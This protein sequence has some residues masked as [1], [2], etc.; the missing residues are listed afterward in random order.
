MG[1]SH[2]LCLALIFNLS[3]DKTD[4]QSIVAYES[5]LPLE[6]PQPNAGLQLVKSSIEKE[7]NFSNGF[8]ICERFKYDLLRQ[9]F[10]PMFFFQPGSE[11]DSY[12]NSAY[13]YLRNDHSFCFFFDFNYIVKDTDSNSFKL[14]TPGNWHHVCFSFDRTS[15]HLI[16]IKDGS[17]TSF[18]TT[19]PNDA[20][21][22]ISS[23]FLDLFMIGKSTTENGSSASFSDVNVW[24][25]PLALQDML[26]WTSC[27]GTKI[28][29][30]IV[31]WTNAQWEHKNM[32][33]YNI[34]Y[35]EMCYHQK[36]GP[37]IHS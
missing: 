7:S 15:L 32:N 9:E 31:D 4:G 35:A 20:A 33:K 16:F 36:I 12:R 29:G 11:S 27:K 37:Y 24:D 26:D 14:W 6:T 13:C 34:D 3:L 21:K 18:D 10:G 17:V 19:V 30:N 23:D 8:T 28:K 2:L 25:F 5:N 22:N 1:G